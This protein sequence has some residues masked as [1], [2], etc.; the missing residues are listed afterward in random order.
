MRVLTLPT[1]VAVAAL[2]AGCSFT[3]L[4]DRLNPHRVDVRQGNYVDQEMVARLKKGMTREQVRFALGTPLVTDVFHADRWDYVYI[5]RPGRGEPQQRVLSVFFDG[6]KLDRV[7]GDVQS[8]DASGAA[9]AAQ[10]ERSRVIEIPP[11]SKQ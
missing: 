11:E 2:V 3:S 10:T 8:G 4:T 1:V 7:S 9:A 5:F 6:D